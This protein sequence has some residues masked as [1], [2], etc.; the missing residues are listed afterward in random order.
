MRGRLDGDQHLLA[1]QLREFRGFAEE[2]PAGIGEFER[3]PAPTGFQANTVARHARLVANDRAATGRNA[4]E[5][6]GLTDVRT[7][8]DHKRRQRG[9]LHGDS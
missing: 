6:S 1:D 2:H 5:K 9:D 3:P 7:P 4:I 8:Y